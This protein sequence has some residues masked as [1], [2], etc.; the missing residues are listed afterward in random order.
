M[1]GVFRGYPPRRSVQ[2]ELAATTCGQQFKGKR[3]ALTGFSGEGLDFRLR[4]AVAF[5]TRMLSAGPELEV[6]AGAE[7][8]HR[9]ASSAGVGQKIRRAIRGRVL[10]FVVQNHLEGGR[11]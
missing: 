4:V 5:S 7:V 11:R 2:A 3:K 8:V 10:L 1:R 6:A 9:A